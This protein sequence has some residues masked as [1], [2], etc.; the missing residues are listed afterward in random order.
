MPNL[1]DYY[2]GVSGQDIEYTG[3]SADIKIRLYDFFYRETGEKDTTKNEQRN[4]MQYA[5]KNLAINQKLMNQLNYTAV[6]V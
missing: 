3:Q 6:S 4:E 2:S 1:S 5:E